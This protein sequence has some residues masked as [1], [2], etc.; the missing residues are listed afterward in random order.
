MKKSEIL[1]IIREEVE[2]VLTNEEAQE[3][4]D[5]D[6]E[7]L[8]EDMMSKKSAVD[9]P[10]KSGRQYGGSKATGVTVDTSPKGV[11]ARQT[12]LKDAA[13]HDERAKSEMDPTGSAGNWTGRSPSQ[14]PLAT[15]EGIDAI[16]E[17]GCGDQKSSSGGEEI[18]INMDGRT[19]AKAVGPDL[20]RKK[21]SAYNMNEDEAEIPRARRQRAVGEQPDK[22]PSKGEAWSVDFATGEQTVRPSRGKKDVPTDVPGGKRR[23][24][25]PWRGRIGVDN[26]SSELEE[27]LARWSELAGIKENDE[28]KD[29]ETEAPKN[30][31]PYDYTEEDGGSIDPAKQAEREKANLVQQTEDPEKK[32]KLKKEGEDNSFSD[33][34]KEIQKK[35][36]EGVFTAKAKKAGM[37]VQEYAAKVL[38]KGSKASTKTKRQAAFAK[39]AATVARE[40]K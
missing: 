1:Q 40:N 37:G 30:P 31:D 36:T 21:L 2:V 33:A 39:G 7:A 11:E 5:L 4:F 6:P 28:N 32:P 26:S 24:R 38:A 17:H 22:E 18:S 34:G 20:R 3:F 35:G 8:L 13:P 10:H 25:L 23:A 12:A 27:E 16:D 19:M 14:N 29:A 15:R 9:P